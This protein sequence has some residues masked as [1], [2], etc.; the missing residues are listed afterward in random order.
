MKATAYIGKQPRFLLGWETYNSKYGYTK[1]HINHAEVISRAWQFITG[2]KTNST[3]FVVDNLEQAFAI[4]CIAGKDETF[5][6]FVTSRGSTFRFTR[7]HALKKFQN[8]RDMVENRLNMIAKS[9][10]KISN[11]TSISAV[12]L[13]WIGIMIRATKR[14]LFN[15][16]NKERVRCYTWLNLC[17][18]IIECCK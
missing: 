17:D 11:S 10:S 1:V 16:C 12:K 3:E 7:K 6:T 2:G 4:K 18:K 8:A 14:D 9:R 13:P 15:L 5:V